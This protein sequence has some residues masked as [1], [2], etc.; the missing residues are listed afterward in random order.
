MAN[1]I[2]S[3]PGNAFVMQGFRWNVETD[4]ALAAGQ[5]ALLPEFYGGDIG[6]E[7]LA[8]PFF[9]LTFRVRSAA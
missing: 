7:Q 2:G 8:T 1:P 4:A 5:L 6:V 9:C 3:I